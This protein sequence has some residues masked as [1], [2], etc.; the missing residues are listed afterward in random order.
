MSDPENLA[1]SPAEQLLELEAIK[2]LKARYFRLMDTKQWLPFSQVFTDD[3]VVDVSHDKH[4]PGGTIVGRA[5]VVD[6]IRKAV[7]RATTVH[8]GHM[9][10]IELLSPSDAQGVWA[11]EDYVEF[12]PSRGI[13]GYGHY[14]EEYRKEKGSW[15]ISKLKLTRLRVDPLG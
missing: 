15:R 8:H 7:G 2:Q 3:V 4:A 5:E 13:R 9:P 11:M 1:L 12:K 10:E 14:H 6:F